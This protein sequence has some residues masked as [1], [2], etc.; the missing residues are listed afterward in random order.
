[1]VMKPFPP[2]P[3]IIGS[4]RFSVASTATAAS[5]AFPSFMSIRTPAIDASECPLVTNPCTPVTAGLCA[6]RRAGLLSDLDPEAFGTSLVGA[7]TTR[8][9]RWLESTPDEP[10]SRAAPELRAIFRRLLV[11]DGARNAQ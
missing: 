11:G 2:A 4:V 6:L 7:V 8:A 3:D 5:A 9:V 10:L 1:M